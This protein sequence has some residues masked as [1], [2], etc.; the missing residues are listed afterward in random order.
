MNRPAAA[1]T[2][3]RA[4]WRW[5]CHFDALRPPVLINR[6]KKSPQARTCRPHALA[7]R[8]TKS[9]PFPGIKGMGGVGKKL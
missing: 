4:Q 8:M 2:D 5:P 1:H 6:Y 7:Q 3:S 9:R